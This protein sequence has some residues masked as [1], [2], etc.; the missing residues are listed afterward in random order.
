M[1]DKGPAKKVGPLPIYGWG[2]VGA[3]TYLAYYLYQ[4]HSSNVNAAQ[5][6]AANGT[7]GGTTPL[8]LDPSV[9]GVASTSS[10]TTN[11]FT[12]WR[13]TVLDALTK[14][15]LSQS[16]ALTAL[17]DY[18]AGQ[19][20][21]DAKSANV[22]KNV[23]GAVGL[24]PGYGYLPVTIA[25]T[26]TPVTSTHTPSETFTTTPRTGGAAPRVPVTTPSVPKAPKATTP[27]KQPKV[28]KEFSPLRPLKGYVPKVT[29]FI[30]GNPKASKKLLN[31]FGVNGTL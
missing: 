9:T 10:N 26:A 13:Q 24:A 31:Q 29:K 4:S 7:V 17:N 8:T 23:L 12:T 27:K 6:A 1:A 5:T 19:A 21:P 22:L 20:I 25:K 11:P 16:Q 14:N 2:L 15:G 18:L 28:V 30:G 3:G